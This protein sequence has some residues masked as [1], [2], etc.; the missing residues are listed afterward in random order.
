MFLLKQV[1]KLSVEADQD[2]TVKTSAKLLFDARIR[3]ESYRG[4][5]W[6]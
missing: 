5:W 6:R 1:G 3:C 4:W 2:I